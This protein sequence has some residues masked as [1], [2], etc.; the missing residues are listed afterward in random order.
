MD[1]KNFKPSWWVIIRD[2]KKHIGCSNNCYHLEEENDKMK[3]CYFEKGI[4]GEED[5]YQ[6]CGECFKAYCET[7]FD[8]DIENIITYHKNHF[9]E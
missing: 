1:N 8:F 7:K 6:L 2:G 3:C 5:N 4:R 9:E